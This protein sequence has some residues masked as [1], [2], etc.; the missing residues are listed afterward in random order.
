MG[1]KSPRN[2][3]QLIEHY[4]KQTDRPLTCV[5]L[6]EHQ[7]LR[8]AAIEEYGDDIQVAQNK[9]SDALGF[10]WRR[11]LINRYPA[12]KDSTSKAWYAYKWAD[13]KQPNPPPQPIRQK[14]RFKIVEGAHDVT[15][16]FDNIT[17]VITTK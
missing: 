13:E 4:L 8:A 15:L 2:T 14:P 3:Y 10:M 5:Q 9:V 12:P 7:D 11:K 16:E 17:I 6:M 1:I